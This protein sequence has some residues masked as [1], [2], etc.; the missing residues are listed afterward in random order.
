[1][2]FDKVILNTANDNPAIAGGFDE[3]QKTIK[4]FYENF[5]EKRLPDP[6]VVYKWHEALVDYCTNQNLTGT[7]FFLRGGASAGHLRRGFLIKAKNADYYYAFSDNY[8][9]SYIYKMA[10]DGEYPNDG[11]ELHKLLTEF[12]D[13]K[14]IAWLNASK[15]KIKNKNDKYNNGERWFPRFP[16]HYKRSGGKTY[17]DKY[18]EELNSFI[19]NGPICSIGECGYKHSHVFDAGN[20]YRIGNKN[21]KISDIIKE[22]FLLKECSKKQQDYVW[23]QT[24]HN[25][26]A[27]NDLLTNA[28]KDIAIA[29]FLRFLDPMNHFLAPKQGYNLYTPQVKAKINDVAEYSHLLDYIKYRFSLRYKNYYNQFCQLIKC[30]HQNGFDYGNEIINIRYL[31]EAQDKPKAKSRAPRTPGKRNSSGTK[32]VKEFVP[33]D[34]KDFKNLLLIKKRAEMTIFYKDGSSVQDTWDAKNFTA[35]SDLINNVSSKIGHRKDRDRIVKV[36]F[37]VK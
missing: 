36:V 20:K 33:T 17:P 9:A 18:E 28:D 7:V 13:T 4:D 30:D 2:N 31:G 14:Q 21:Y 16:V 1:M 24:K 37:E 35:G 11:T 27:E 15:L 3:E 29:C 34:L 32:I 8:M 23:D 10:L 12:V 22:K 6:N 5:I 26:V 25:Y 19:I